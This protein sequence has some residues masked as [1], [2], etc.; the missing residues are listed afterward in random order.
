MVNTAVFHVLTTFLFLSEVHSQCFVHRGLEVRSFFILGP[1][2][3]NAQSAPMSSNA[4]HSPSSDSAQSQS[5]FPF[6]FQ[7]FRREQNDDRTSDAARHMAVKNQR[8]DSYALRVLRFIWP[9]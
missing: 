9:P 6:A 7:V 3:T 2:S 5:S 8:S 1:G 4:R